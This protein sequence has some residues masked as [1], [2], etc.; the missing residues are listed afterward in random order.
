MAYMDPYKLG[1]HP[2]TLRR[3]VYWTLQGMAV[4]GNPPRVMR[5]VQL[6]PSADWERI[7]T[8]WHECWTMEAVKINW[9]VVIHDILPNNER[10][11]KIRL[12]DTPLCG[13]GEKPDTIQHRV[14]ACDEGARIWL[15]NKRR[16]AWILRID[17]VQIAPDLTTRPQ[18]RLWPPQRHRAVLWILT[19]MVWYRIKESRAYTEQHY[20]DFLRRT[21]WKAYQAKHRRNNVG[22]YLEIL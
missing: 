8:N 13:H 22:N 19:Q 21:R 12:V 11:H 3:R 20:S 14:T 9:Y 1:E 17:A 5:I 2:R 16:I 15:W 18:F 7:W 4:A 6:Q 10:L